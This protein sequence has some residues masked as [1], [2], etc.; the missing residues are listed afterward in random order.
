MRLTYWVADALD[1]SRAYSIR[2]RTR[3]RCR[4]LVLEQGQYAEGYGIPRKVVV[5]Y[6]DAFQLVTLALGEGGIE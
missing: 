5:E 6:K 4:E 2:A 1:D 3:T